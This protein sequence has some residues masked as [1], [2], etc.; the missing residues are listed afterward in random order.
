MTDDLLLHA[1]R[2][3]RPGNVWDSHGTVAI[4]ADRIAAVGTDVARTAKQTLHFP[5]ADIVPGLIDL[6]AHP[7]KSGS[8]FGVDPDIHLLPR[9]TTTVLSQGDA[10]A[11]GCEEFLRTT[12][13]KSRTRVRLAINLS[14]VG[15]STT[16]GCFENPDWIDV[17]ACVRTVERFPE[18]IWG[19]A[20]NVS[21]NACGN[22]D[23]R[24]VLRRGLLAAEQTRLPLL[25][26]MRRPEDWPLADQLEYLRS[27]DVV[28]YCFRRTPHCIIERGRVLPAVRNA[29]ERGILFDV[30]HGRASFDFEVAETAI[31]DGFAPD[32]ISTDLQ[33]GHRG[34]EPV[35]DLPLVMSKLIAAGMSE[36]DVFAA[37]TSRPADVLGMTGTIGEI[38]PG[39]CADLTVLTIGD[40]VESLCDTQ[41][42]QR[43][44]RRWKAVLTIRAGQVV[45]PGSTA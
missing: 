20:V 5:D 6:H 22:T 39:A 35:H 42:N 13:A 4:C 16:G 29:R 27:G 9:G 44:A 10:G 23:P 37:V 41:G 3:L 17:E 38:E 18:Q 36:T 24:D 32:T 33:A 43:L 31:R 25:Y 19:I 2:V 14:S 11:S 30:G 7:A 8:V 1:R 15:E 45:P 12:I 28:T 40:S 21:H 26:G 34:Q